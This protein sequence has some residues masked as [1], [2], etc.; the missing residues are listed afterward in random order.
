MPYG[1]TF[2]LDLMVVRGSL[3]AAVDCFAD[4]VAVDCFGD[5]VAVDCFG[6][7][8]VVGCFGD[9]AVVAASVMLR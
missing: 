1:S 5:V 6:D 9:A 7:A 3:W 8:A 4:V 2:L